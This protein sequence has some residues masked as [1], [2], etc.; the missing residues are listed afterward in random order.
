MQ[1]SLTTAKIIPIADS[2]TALK[3]TKANGTT[4]VVIVDTTNSYVG[5]GCT[6]SVGLDVV[7]ATGFRVNSAASGGYGL[8]VNN[9]ELNFNPL[10]DTEDTA[11]YINYRGYNLGSTRYRD[12]YICNGKTG[13][14]AM[15]DGS[16]GNVGIGVTNPYAILTVK[17]QQ[18]I[19]TSDYS[20]GNVGSA[21]QFYLGTATGD[22]VS[23]IQAVKSGGTAGTNLAINPGGGDVVMGQTNAATITGN[24]DIYAP[25]A[26]AY[27]SSGY[28]M[29]IDSDGRIGRDSSARRFK[30]N[31][32]PFSGDV[33]KVLTVP[34]IQYTLK[35]DGSHD[36]GFLA[37]DFDENGC[38]E[39]V[40]YDEGLPSYVK[41]DRITMYH[42]EIIKNLLARIKA[43]EAA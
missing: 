30:D 4:D 2:T 33:F 27:Q 34:A 31:I 13:T 26:R 8:H 3:I 36:I 25:A 9:N 1:N 20:N 24:G 22:C 18:Y 12:L 21:L 10:S 7:A 11:G 39:L 35:S 43:L 32:E 14:I 23:H 5:L 19:T 29:K 17:L 42:N 37:E 6:P 41:Y 16:S 40:G 15:F 28:T 38:K